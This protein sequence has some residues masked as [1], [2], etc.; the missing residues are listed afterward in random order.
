MFN[1][2]LIANRGVAAVRIARTLKRLG[3]TSVALRTS[4]E[5]GNDYFSSFDEVWDLSGESVAETYLNVSQILT[6]AA[7]AGACAVHPGYGFLSENAEFASQVA[8]AGFAFLGPSPEVIKTFGLKHEARAIAE[9]QRVPVLRGTDILPDIAAARAAAEQ[10]GYPLLLKSTAG[11]GGIGM[12]RCDNPEQLDAAFGSVTALA[13]SNFTS[14]GVFIEKCITQARHVEVQLFGDGKGNVVILGDRDCSLQ[15]RNQKLVEECPA[16]QLP[17]SIRASMHESAR[18]LA[19]SVNYASAGTVE[20]L[21]DAEAEQYYFLEVNTR[22]Q[23]EHGVSELVYGVDIVEWMIRLAVGDLPNCAELEQS[24]QAKGAAVQVRLYAEDPFDNYRPTPGTVDVLFPQQGRIDNWVGSGSLV[25]HWF[26]PLL[27]NVMAH[28]ET[29]TRAIEQLR[30]TLERTQIYGT[31]TN[32]ALLLQALDNERF[33]AGEVDTGLLE[34]V[35]Y[36][37]NELEIIRSG[38][39]MTVQAFP[40]RQGYWDVGVPPSGPMDDLSFQLGNRMLG[41]PVTAAGLEMVLAG[42][43]IKFRNSTL[44]VL[45][46]AQVAASLNGQAVESSKP[47]AVAPGQTLSIDYMEDGLRSYLLLRGGLDVAEFLGSSATFVL[48]QFGGHQGKR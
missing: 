44:C 22:L 8:E 32:V 45:T 46:G 36:Q 20:F 27:A 15:R 41:N 34:T 40:G 5:R 10:V 21:Y 39:E 19:A 6:I 1:K 13:Q 24:V 25:S 33:R 29:R 18:A 4:A 16:P 7:E 3:I 48:G 14:A 42:A 38:L 30:E 35:A 28:A 17:T 9:S 2:V 11:G 12:Q 23:V 47:F 37:P 31:T 43:K 26:D